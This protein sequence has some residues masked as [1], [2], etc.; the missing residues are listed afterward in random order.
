MI[1]KMVF[2]IGTS[3]DSIT[4]YRLQFYTKIDGEWKMYDIGKYIGTIGTNTIEF[5]KITVELTNY[6]DAEIHNLQYP[7]LYS[8]RSFTLRI[9]TG[10]LVVTFKE[11][12]KVLSGMYHGFYYAIPK[13]VSIYDE[14]DALLFKGSGFTKM[15]MNGASYATHFYKTTELEVMR[16]YPTDVIGTIET[17]DNS[18]ISNIYQI[19]N[20][21][22]SDITPDNTNIKY[23]LSF[24]GRNTYKT[25]KNNT[26]STVDVSVNT[27]IMND[28]MTKTEVES[29]TSNEFNIALTDNKTLDVLIGMNTQNEYSTPSIS[30]IKVLYLRIV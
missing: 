11:G 17:N 28:G 4:L 2:D 25:Y 21:N 15:V 22:L 14:N 27:N 20:I 7:F 29:L 5:E 26:W 24:D 6:T 9:G 8:S 19:E 12:L 30:E 18:H 3:G 10:P 16:V 23:L 1:K 13:S